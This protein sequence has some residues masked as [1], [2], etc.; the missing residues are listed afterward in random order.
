MIIPQAIIRILRRVIALEKIT[1]FSRDLI[2]PNGMWKTGVFSSV[3]SIAGRAKLFDSAQPL[4]F[5]S[6]DQVKN[7]LVL[8]VDVIMDRIA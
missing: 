2:H 6:I 5:L 4:E 1:D 7:H 3:E 8:N